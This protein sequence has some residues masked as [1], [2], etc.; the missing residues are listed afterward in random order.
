MSTNSNLTTEASRIAKLYRSAFNNFGWRMCV[1]KKDG[2]IVT[3]DPGLRT[4]LHLDD[5]SSI[6]QA[7]LFQILHDLS[8]NR[9]SIEEMSSK[10]LTE[11][12]HINL[13]ND[14]RNQRMLEITPVAVANEL[15]QE[16]IVVGI[17]DCTQE[18]DLRA[19]LRR[20][21]D[22]EMM[23]ADLSSR[24]IN[25]T[26]STIDKTINIALREIG[27][28]FAV[29]HTYINLFRDDGT[30]VDCTHEW[31]QDG[32][33]PLIDQVQG[34][35]IDSF[36]YYLKYVENKET[37]VIN[38]LDELPETAK[39]EYD[40][41]AAQNVK[42]ALMV[43]LISEDDMIGFLRLDTVRRKQRWEEDSIR[44]LK[45][46]ADLLGNA[47]VRRQAEE[48]YT[49]A[50]ENSLHGYMIH[51]QGVIKF[52]NPRLCEIFGRTA[53]ELC[54]MTPEENINLLHPEDRERIRRIINGRERGEKQP[55][56][57]E[58][59]ALRPDGSVIY[60]ENFASRIIYRGRPA[61]QASVVDITDRKN[62]EML[63]R[64]QRDLSVKLSALSSLENS[65]KAVFDSA[66][67]IRGIDSGGFYIIDDKTG[68][69]QLVYQRG[70]SAEFVQANSYFDADSNRARLAKMG[71]SVYY[72]KPQ[73]EDTF[74]TEEKR[75]GLTWVA[76]LPVTHDGRASGL[77]NFSSHSIHS[78][79][80][81]NRHALEAIVGQLGR[82]IG[83][84]QAE[85]E[86]LQA[87]ERVTS[88]I[89]NV[90]DMV[91]FQ[92]LDGSL[93]LLNEANAKI[94][95]YTI[96]EF[97]KDPQ[98]WRKIV[99]PEDVKTAEEFFSRHPEGVPSFETEY[100]IRD[101]RGHW[102][103]ILSRMVATRDETGKIIGYNCIDRDISDRKQIEEALRE[104]EM[105]YHELFHSVME[106][107]VMLDEDEIIQFCNPAFA[108]ILEADSISELIGENFIRFIPADQIDMV[109]AQTLMRKEGHSSQYELRLKTIRDNQRI[110]LI[111][112]TPRFNRRGG[113]IGT[114][115]AMMDIT[116]TRKLQEIASR[117]QRLET[118][119]KIAG[120]VAHDFNNLLGPMIAYPG[121]VRE[122]L[123]LGSSGTKFLDDMEKAAQHMAEINQQLL[124]LGRRAHYIQEP[125]NLNE[126][127]LDVIGQVYPLPDTISVEKELDSK[128]MNIKGGKSQ[129]TRVISNL[130]SNALDS[131][132]EIGCLTIKTENYYAEDISKKYG[133]VP[134][135]EYVKLTISDT[136]CGI[137]ADIINN[138][139]DPFFST[140]TADKKRGSG[141]GLS[142]VHAVIQDH[143]G[144]IDL[145]SE[146]GKG[147]SF[148]IYLPITRETKELDRDDDIPG[149]SELVLVV[150]DDEI[151]RDVTL[152]LLEKLGY[153]VTVSPSGEDALKLLGEHSFDLLALDLIM[154][155]GIDGAETFRRAL[156]INPSQKAII[157]SGYS[158]RVRAEVALKLGAGAYVRKPLTLKSLATAVREV[159]DRK[160]NSEIKK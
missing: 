160:Q 34:I 120:Q 135:G 43:P 125:L 64:L 147:T 25:L 33:S 27:K 50:I 124:T 19:E 10:L 102:H 13:R 93:A 17:R 15:S 52:V 150:D 157:V 105:R 127:V 134:R 100:R 111:S 133:K 23:L 57:Y 137:A 121:F 91:Y 145:K 28:Y 104:S 3:V 149:G 26:Y 40:H 39:N 158:D 55:S 30:I 76:V 51:Q 31:T 75:E 14:G 7:N 66:F 42:S 47:L 5:S 44:Y 58:Y 151:Q 141:L 99:H 35:H 29:D 2:T 87:E 118:A 4:F 24:M 82:V 49:Q 74:S 106:G 71:K 130:T 116:E 48:I 159:L 46:C 132:Q 1:C 22:F 61:T 89:Q 123:P 136:G 108:K 85:K 20:R 103:W 41:L 62:A 83:R 37:L 80:R 107:M 72:S 153:K 117:A 128:L 101:K 8:S 140:K 109:E 154:P 38:S 12:Q 155:P 84:I 69:L 110:V 96:E 56:H 92:G 21:R 16:L 9:I 156:Q 79:P 73:L 45:I 129:I 113:F 54:A 142:V 94:T 144:F 88:F 86:R 115:A 81:S 126:V 146:V 139:F 59:R 138:I 18:Y 97:N 60:L 65:Y 119:G 90:D 143:N 122:S 98:L 53:S 70:I 32:F 78:I 152:R 11:N 148:Y 131:M 36:P 95:G 67:K 114:V 68:D 6:Y 77:I 63:L 112:V